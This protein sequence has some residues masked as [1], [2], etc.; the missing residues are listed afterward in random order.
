MTAK[1]I[2]EEINKTLANP[3]YFAEKY[4][5]VINGKG[6]TKKMNLTQYQKKILEDLFIKGSTV[7][8][9][10]KGLGKNG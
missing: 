5:C 6:E 7:I 4:C 2:N 1:E 8:G 3:A 10:K 9:F